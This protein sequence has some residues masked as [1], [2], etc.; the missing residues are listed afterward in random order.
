MAISE[1]PSIEKLT[2]RLLEILRA[3]ANASGVA[4]QGLAPLSP[5]AAKE[6]NYIAQVTELAKRHGSDSSA[7]DLAALAKSLE[8]QPHQSG[9]LLQ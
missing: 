1:N 9:R 6:D 2:H 3:Q 4:E 5:N 7:E 8:A